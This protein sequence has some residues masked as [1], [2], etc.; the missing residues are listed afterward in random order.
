[1][2]QLTRR[3]AIIG[4]SVIT[5]APAILTAR[6]AHAA[7]FNY[8]LG[9]NMPAEH[10]LNKR[11]NEAAARIAKET[12]GQVV[13][14]IFPSNQLGNDA[15]MLSQL[16]SGGLESFT[17]S[18]VN[19]LS[20]LVPVSAIYGLGFAFSDED[21]V[22]RALDG[23]LG[24]YLR[25]QFSKVGLVALEGVWGTGF[26]QM[27]NNVRPIASPEDLRGLKMRVPVSPM[28]TS[29]FKN[30]GSAPVSINFAEVFPALQTKVVDGQ[31]NPLSTIS[32]AKLY[33]VQKYCSMTNHM[34]DGFL[35]MLNQKAWDRL[36]ESAR[37]IVARN[38]NKSCL[39]MR[40]DIAKLNASLRSDLESKGM[41]FNAPNLAPFRAMVGKSNYYEDWR[42]K[43]GD[44]A[45]AV[46][47]KYTGK[48]G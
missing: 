19:V 47:E 12:N 46:L 21:T 16:R 28:W 14:N 29:L 44:E 7:E 13:F 42:R 2:T 23:D 26:R 41:V 3:Q 6:S 15:D 18:G 25:A 11:A 1:M 37:A 10:P 35:F 31:E 34:W 39:D 43:F 8:K 20:Q 36:P 33:E 40:A 27:T 45:W 48:L 5:A 38:F 17:I 32:I 9:T 24:K 4:A 30:L 22:Y